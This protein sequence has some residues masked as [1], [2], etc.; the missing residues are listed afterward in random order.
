VCGLGLVENWDN[1]FEFLI[2][3][4]IPERVIVLEVNTKSE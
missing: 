2:Q 4:I 1:W 3:A